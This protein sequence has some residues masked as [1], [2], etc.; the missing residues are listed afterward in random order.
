MGVEVQ[1]LIYF[2]LT[3]LKNFDVTET[4]PPYLPPYSFPI[5]PLFHE[6]SLAQAQP[7]PENDRYEAH[8]VET[9]LF[10]VSARFS[11]Q[12][13]LLPLNLLISSIYFLFPIQTYHRKCHSKNK[14]IAFL[15]SQG[16]YHTPEYPP[17][18]SLI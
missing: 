1:V 7:L 9:Q 16:K 4:Y 14:W 5:E 13:Q 12:I 17:L 11:K 6:L 2:L 18:F 10:H 8:S 15:L 3:S